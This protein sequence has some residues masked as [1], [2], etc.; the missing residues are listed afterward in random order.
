LIGFAVSGT[1]IPADATIKAVLTDRSFQ[2]N[3]EATA[4]AGATA[5]TF[6]FLPVPVKYE[7]AVVALLAMRIKGDMGISLPPDVYADLKR[8]ADDGWNGI[9]AG[10]L[11]DRKARFDRNIAVPAGTW[12]IDSDVFV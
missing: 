6:D 12:D 10:Y 1:G 4:S 9:L 3:T 2:L 5:L 11:P 7:G 8:D